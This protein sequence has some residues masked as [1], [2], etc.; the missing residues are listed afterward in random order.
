MNRS[1]AALRPL[2]AA[3]ALFALVT[4]SASAGEPSL[5]STARIDLSI[6]PP[7]PTVAVALVVGTD[8]KPVL[9]EGM[10]TPTAYSL[11]S[12]KPPADRMFELRLFAPE[13]RV[14][15][16]IFRGASTTPESG[17]GPND[18]TIMWMSSAAANEELRILVRGQ[19]AGETPF[20]LGAKLFPKEDPSE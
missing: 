2:A 16:I 9:V 19:V 4:V 15:M 3:F 10:A 14:A 7:I 1:T 12:F 17:A 13:E 8:E 6:E 5:A 18:G 11:F 20:K